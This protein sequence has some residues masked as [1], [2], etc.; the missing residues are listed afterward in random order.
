MPPAIKGM[1]KRTVAAIAISFIGISLLIVL[2]STKNIGAVSFSAL[3]TIVSLESLFIAF[4]DRVTS[5]NLKEL[6]MKLEKLDSIQRAV[7]ARETEP[8]IDAS[9][10]SPSSPCAGDSVLPGITCEIYGHGPTTN[11][12]IKSI[13]GTKYTFRNIEGIISDSE[14]SHDIAKDKLNWLL[15][16]KLADSFNIDG[17]KLY[18]LSPKG[19]KVFAQILN[20]PKP[21]A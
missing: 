20:P 19:S 9:L 16:N 4:S 11:K 21:K 12:V 13:G 6:S 3:F 8:N 2:L 5:I 7:V 1:K 15:I 18:A 14:L 17:E 10:K